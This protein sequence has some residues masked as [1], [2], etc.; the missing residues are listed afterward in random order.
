MEENN[1]SLKIAF[2][3]DLTTSISKMCVISYQARNVLSQILCVFPYALNKF[4]PVEL[5]NNSNFLYLVLIVNKPHSLCCI[6][7]LVIF[8]VS[9]IRIFRS[10]L[11]TVR[12]Y[13]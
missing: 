1:F 12:P 3:I 13:T 10:A 2:Y 5:N 7:L 4:T 6:N 9:E 11:D 8:F